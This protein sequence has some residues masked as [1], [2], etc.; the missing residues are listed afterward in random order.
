MDP[1]NP[2]PSYRYPGLYRGVVEDVDDTRAVARYRVRVNHVHEGSIPTEHLPWSETVSAFAGRGFGDIP[3]YDVD[4]LV[5][6]MFEGGDRQYPVVIGSWLS[7]RDGINDRPPEQTNNYGRDRKRWQR[8]DRKGNLVELS[9]RDEDLWVRIKS[10]NTEVIVTQRDDSV[11][12]D[13][14]HG[15]VDIEAAQCR[16]TS[17]Q[18][19][20][21]SDDV[22]LE[23]KGKTGEDEDGEVNIYS[24]HRVTLWAKEDVWIGQY[25]TKDTDPQPKQSP[26]V[27]VQPR[28]AQIGVKNPSD[29]TKRTWVVNIEALDIIRLLSDSRVYVEAPRVDVAASQTATVKAPRVEAECNTAEVVA[30]SQIAV[31]TPTF[32]IE[33]L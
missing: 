31:K 7:H 20:L 5:A 16:V 29:G 9:E 23:A 18:T 25:L 32:R 24:N 6:V 14:R 22:T 4:D 19:T 26:L 21:V 1:E 27:R 3:N 8:R 28:T 33:G 30:N 10:G 2:L 13:A 17:Q 12:I 11:K 15:S